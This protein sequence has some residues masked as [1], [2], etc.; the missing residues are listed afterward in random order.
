MATELLDRAN[1]LIQKFQYASIGVID[2]NGYP[3]VSAISLLR[4]RA[5][6]ELFFT[7]TLDSNK[8]RRLLA[9]NKASINCFDDDNNI[10]LVGEV[11]IV[12][13]TKRKQEC[14]QSWVEN[15]SDIYPDGIS[16]P[17]YCFV[18]FNTK[19]ASLWIDNQKSEFEME[20]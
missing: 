17:N 3:S 16:D 9:N 10:T 14:W 12:S 6:A 8:A 5:I 15:G 7:T 2:E 4:P 18:K 13:D 20:R 1:E 11:E 19:R